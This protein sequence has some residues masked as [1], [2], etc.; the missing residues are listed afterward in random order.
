MGVLPSPG[1]PGFEEGQT[2]QVPR[3]TEWWL[4]GPSLPEDS[5]TL[6]P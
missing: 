6:I 1:T 5:A 3:V 4:G 2:V